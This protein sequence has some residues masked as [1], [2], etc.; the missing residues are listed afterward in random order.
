M[1][2]M[3]FLVEAFYLNI[4]NSIYI[5]DNIVRYYYNKTIISVNI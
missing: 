5:L 4:I 2:V 3:P 1:G